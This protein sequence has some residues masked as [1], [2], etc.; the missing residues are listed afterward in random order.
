MA[1]QSLNVNGYVLTTTL[2][3]AVFSAD[4]LYQ[5]SCS[6]RPFPG[7]A[8]TVQLITSLIVCEHRS[9]TPAIL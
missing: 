2:R 7:I 9:D 5:G 6:P 1:G 3:S 4:S 8:Y